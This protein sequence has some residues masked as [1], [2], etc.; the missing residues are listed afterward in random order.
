M[1][2]CRCLRLYDISLY[3]NQ[4]LPITERHSADDAAILASMA[5]IHVANSGPGAA[6]LRSIAILE[7]LLESSKHN[8]DAL[9]IQ[10]RLCLRLGLPSLSF[11]HYVQLS[12]KSMQH[13]TLSWIL[14]THISVIH[15]YPY[16][17]QHSTTE[18]PPIIDLSENITS[19]LDWHVATDQTLSDSMIRMLREGQYNMFF[20]T[21]SLQ[22]SLKM[23]FSRLLLVSE[24]SRIQNTTGVSIQKE[25]TNIS[26]KRTLMLMTCADSAK[27][28]I[29]GQIYDNRDWAVFPN[30]EGEPDRPFIH[31]LETFPGQPVDVS[32]ETSKAWL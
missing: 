21:L 2:V 5:L 10:I 17:H 16:V 1:F 31:L 32:G 29:S 13:A 20:D 9:L 23:G 30:Y 24:R 6:L 11:E 22:R 27:G 8:Y 15:P 7:T 12:A 3:L 19:A 18:A 25:Y 14:Y 28:D 4:E 26:S